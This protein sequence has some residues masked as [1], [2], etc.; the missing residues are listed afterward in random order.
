MWGGFPRRRRASVGSCGDLQQCCSQSA[1]TTNASAL[2]AATTV[3]V[4]SPAAVCSHDRRGR[5]YA[6]TLIHHPVTSA[7]TQAEAL[8]TIKAARHQGGC[9]QPGLRSDLA[10]ADLDPH[11]VYS[12]KRLGDRDRDKP[13]SH[14][15]RLKPP[16]KA[17]P[18]TDIPLPRRRP[19]RRSDHVFGS[20]PSAFRCPTD[21]VSAIQIGTIWAQTTAHCRGRRLQLGQQ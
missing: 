14:R 5:K 1:A 12:A 13:V 11:V 2:P 21:G 7:P 19:P 4:V 15:D 20:V 17:P 6:S 9:S 8:A 3:P 16:D 18:P 10:I